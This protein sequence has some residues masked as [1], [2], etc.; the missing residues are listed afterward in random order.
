M[1]LDELIHSVLGNEIGLI[2]QEFTFRVI[3]KFWKKESKN[4]QISF[5][6]SQCATPETFIHAIKDK[7]EV[8]RSH[9][10]EEIWVMQTKSDY[11][12]PLKWVR[13]CGGRLKIH[14]S[15]TF[16]EHLMRRSQQAGNR[17]FEDP[18]Y[19]LDE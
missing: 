19:D 5:L 9:C 13:D 10:L 15:D 17:D 7:F 3:L 14:V 11:E 18:L 16:K 2:E 4:A 6:T 8:K 1:E 12:Q